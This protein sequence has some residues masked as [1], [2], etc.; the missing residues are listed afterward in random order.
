MPS[1]RPQQIV[2]TPAPKAVFLRANARVVEMT[3]PEALAVARELLRCVRIA[4]DA[5]DG[6][7]LMGMF[8]LAL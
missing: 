3:P 4:L 5:E 1:T 6:Q 8:N 7:A 2:L